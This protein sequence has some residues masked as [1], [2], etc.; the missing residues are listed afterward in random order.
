MDIKSISF[1]NSLNWNYKNL[2]LKKINLIVGK[3]AS[4]KTKTLN[5]IIDIL[6]FITQEKTTVIGEYDIEFELNGLKFRY[7]ISV[8]FMN[9]VG[10]FDISKEQLYVNDKLYIDRN[11]EGKGKIYSEVNKDY[12]E[13]SIDT[14]IPAIFAKRDKIQ[15]SYLDCINSWC[16]SV[17]FC[18]FGTD[19]GIRERFK[20]TDVFSKDYFFETDKV[21]RNLN[22]AINKMK[23]GKELK[24]KLIEQMEKLD[25]FIEDIQ[26]EKYFNSYSLKI[27]EKDVANSVSQEELSQG[28]FRAFSILAHSLINLYENK[29][30]LIV[31]DDI[32]EGLDYD[33]STKLIG[34]LIENAKKSNSQLIM[35]TNDRY[36]MNKVPL[37]YWQIIERTK[38]K[39]EFYSFE[40]DDEILEDFDFTGLNNFD[41]LS[42]KFYLQNKKNEK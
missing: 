11:Y 36:V 8:F 12:Y 3:N 22:F 30:N 5:S 20:D 25:Y 16:R 10:N 35:S 9:D 33:R 24:E 19:L 37:K 14:N 29:E 6:K 34:L 40:E 7:K 32:G 4:G 17:M 1:N 42:T 18:R 15:H 2:K 39:I 21:V 28:M 38:D 13:F 41:F 26:F 27:I 23:Y 31:I